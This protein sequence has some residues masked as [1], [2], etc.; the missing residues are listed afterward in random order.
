VSPPELRRAL[1]AIQPPDEL[2]SMRRSWQL[3]RAAFAERE[4]TPWS[5]RHAR[6]LV[7]GA[8]A[9]AALAALLSP[10][11]RDVIADGREAIGTEN[12]A[13]V[14]E[15]R[16]PPFSLPAEGRVL[17]RAPSGVWVVEA[18]GSKRR[19]GDFDEASWSPGGLAVASTRSRL[20]AIGP[21][22]EVR[23][24]L[25]R[26][27]VHD[28]RWAPSGS[29]IAYLSGSNLRVVAADKTGDRRVDGAADVAPA[30]RPGEQ[31]VVAYVSADGVLTVRDTDTDETLWTSGT[32]A[33]PAQ[34]EW[35]SDGQRLVA[36]VP[37]SDSRFALTVYD[38]AGR[39]LQSL[40]LP[41]TFVDAAFAP[42]DHRIALLRRQ[43]AEEGETSELLVVD[44]D[45]IRR[46]TPVFDGRGRFGD[47][48]WS[49][50]ARWLLLGWQSADQWLFIRS[51]AVEKVKAVSSLAQQFD[52]GGTGL[53]PFPRIEG[54]C[55]AG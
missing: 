29:R 46:Q 30:W 36:A 47:V 44:A 19:L 31:P 55:C 28:A 16:T 39:R 35:S 52:P 25:A 12:V 11:G 41:G 42:D 9:I 51:T 49:P 27:R 48:A 24:S 20:A 40:P 3:A 50:G 32:R 26:P 34:L 15:A 38:E 43:R 13:G 8:V 14:P 21:T 6:W 37:L 4:P 53:G 54:W 2:G 1:L 23:W 18:N 22:G 7:A 5:R 33:M 45:S 17:V 10:Q